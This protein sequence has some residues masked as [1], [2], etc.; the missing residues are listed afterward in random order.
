MVALPLSESNHDQTHLIAT[1]LLLL[2]AASALPIQPRKWQTVVTIADMQ[3]PDAAPG[4]AA[5][6][7]A[8]PTTVTACVTPQQAAD[9]PARCCR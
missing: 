1:P 3:I 8:H 4:T 5:A 2:P 6:M 7:R 9:G